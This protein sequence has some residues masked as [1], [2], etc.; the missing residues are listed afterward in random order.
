M[1]RELNMG[2][3]NEILEIG[4]AIRDWES[5]K[6]YI[7]SKGRKKKIDRIIGQMEEDIKVIKNEKH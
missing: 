4:Q 5:L 1:S 6:K 7:K 2:E 3:I